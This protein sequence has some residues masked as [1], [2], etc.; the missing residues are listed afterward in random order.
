MTGDLL[1][2]RQML[3]S[4]ILL[5]LMLGNFGCDQTGRS[6]DD[7]GSGAEFDPRFIGT[8]EELSDNRLQE[9]SETLPPNLVPL[10]GEAGILYVNGSMLT[11]AVERDGP[12]VGIEWSIVND[13]SRGTG[14]GMF[15]RMS[16]SPIVTDCPAD[17]TPLTGG[18]TALDRD[19]GFTHPLRR[20]YDSHVGACQLGFNR[21]FVISRELLFSGLPDQKPNERVHRNRHQ[22]GSG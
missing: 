2:I 21:P 11:T 1:F 22:C 4:L 5:S 17:G 18:I 12:L 3:F 8:S 7:L 19:D 10:D 6:L 20:Y 16:D 15:L 9:L 13:E 14:L